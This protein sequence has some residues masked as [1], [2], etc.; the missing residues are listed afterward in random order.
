[1]Y[2]DPNTQEINNIIVILLTKALR[3][4]RFIVHFDFKSFWPL[5]IYLFFLEKLFF[6]KFNNKK[7]RRQNLNLLPAIFIRQLTHKFMFVQWSN[8][9]ASVRQF[10]HCWMNIHLSIFFNDFEESF[11]L[12]FRNSDSIYIS[13]IN[14]FSLIYD[15]LSFNMY[16]T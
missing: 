6:Q 1:M 12:N 2:K 11:L 5:N 3:N 9:N 4:N 10:S 7:S 15:E 14:I 16:V 13:K 8:L